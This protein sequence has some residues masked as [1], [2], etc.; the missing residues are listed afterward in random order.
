MTLYKL[1]VGD[2]NKGKTPSLLKE[3]FLAVGQF[4]MLV[5]ENLF[6]SIGILQ[7]R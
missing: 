2:L 1:Y 3:D 5:D 6:L 7:G 4:D